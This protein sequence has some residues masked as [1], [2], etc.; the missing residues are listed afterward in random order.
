MRGKR[1]QMVDVGEG[2][3]GEDV[4]GTAD[5]RVSWGMTQ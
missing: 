3:C 1:W 4:P 5:L 2:A